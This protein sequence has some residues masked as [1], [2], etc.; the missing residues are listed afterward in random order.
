MPITHIHPNVD[1][2]PA[3]ALANRKIINTTVDGDNEV[4]IAGIPN[5]SGEG[6]TVTMIVAELPDSADMVAI[7]IKNETLLAAAQAIKFQ[8]EEMGRG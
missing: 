7:E 5:G 6:A 3:S 1:R 4:W 8:C 2:S